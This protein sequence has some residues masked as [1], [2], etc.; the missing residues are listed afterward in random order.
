[1]RTRLERTRTAQADMTRGGFLEAGLRALLYV[2]RGGGADERQFNALEALRNAA[3]ENERAPLSQVKDIMRQQAAL[4][5]LD[6]KRA[7]ATIAGNAARRSWP[8][9]QGFCRRSTTSSRRTANP[10]PA[11]RGRFRRNKPLVRIRRPGKPNPSAS[12]TRERDEIRF[13]TAN[14]RKIQKAD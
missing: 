6:E 8:R 1:M 9:A 11:R 12:K 3:P 4:L 10:M 2:L 5:R 7:V 14:A 13:Q